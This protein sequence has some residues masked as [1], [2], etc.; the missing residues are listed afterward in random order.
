M[1][2]SPD[3]PASGDRSVD[4][5]RADVD[6]LDRELVALINRRAGIAE[7]IGRM[8]KDVGQRVY[9]PAREEEIL[10][11][12]V[13]QNDG[14]L[15]DA[16]VRAVFR[17]LISG[18]RAAEKAIRVAY[19]GPEYSYSHLAAIQR[20]GQ[21][22]E[23]AP[24]GAIASVFEEVERGHADFGLAPIENS[25]DG[26]VID[27]L[28]CLANSPVRICGEVPLAIHHCLLGICRRDEIERVY[29]KPQALSQCRNWLAKHLP[30]VQL[31][32]IA[33]TSEAARLAA[34]EKGVA[35]V[36][37]EQAGVNHH[38]RVLARNIEDNPDNVTRFA[39]ISDRHAAQTGDDKTSILFSIAHKS[40]SLA[41][42][43]EIFS[44][45]G[46]NLT[47]IESFPIP[48]VRGRYLFFVEFE[49]H[50][51]DAAAVTALEELDRMAQKIVV[52]GSYAR[53]EP[54]G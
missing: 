37:S 49:G 27:T 46:L 39:V 14:P 19:L 48:G 31:I 41:S 7:S 26:R 35:A 33:S 13:A 22:L 21:S 11:R 23:L 1:S 16:C 47:W 43:L 17:E 6:Q 29:S 42:G 28:Y 8:K 3:N 34:G 51:E 54:V 45:N 52:L 2:D 30:A 20:F 36:A 18:S 12:V 50:Q 24:V 15:S 40:G 10:N 4:A 9:A 32:E 53:M 25:T 38:L 44:K 5:L